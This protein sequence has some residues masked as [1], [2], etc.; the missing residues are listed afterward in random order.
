ML[1][2][3]CSLGLGCRSTTNESVE[4]LSNLIKYNWVEPMRMHVCV[5]FNLIIILQHA[6]RRAI[7][8][9]PLLRMPKWLWFY[10]LLYAISDRES[11]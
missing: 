3:L 7:T 6:T 1:Q 4:V 11:R 8:A 10:K 2:G 9:A 5:A